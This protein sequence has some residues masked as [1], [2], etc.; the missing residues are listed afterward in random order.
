MKKTPVNLSVL[1]PIFN[2]QCGSRQVTG[3]I[4]WYE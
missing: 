2:Y 3:R 4:S 1:T